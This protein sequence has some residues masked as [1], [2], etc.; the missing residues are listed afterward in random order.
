[1]NDCEGRA[2]NRDA[3]SQSRNESIGE[4]SFAAPKFAFE[5]QDR[6]SIDFFRELPADQQI[7]QALNRL[8]FGPKPG[9]VARVRAIGLDNWIDL[10]L[11]PDRINDNVLNDFVNAK[12]ATLR[13]GQNDLLEQYAVQQRERREIKRDKADSAKGKREDFLDEC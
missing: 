2:G 4:L 9:D 13:Q 10:Q 12:Y 3:A 5:R 6:P 1:M 11:H 7:I 8:T